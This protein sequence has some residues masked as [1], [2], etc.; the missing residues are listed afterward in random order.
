VL[1]GTV[2]LGD[3]IASLFGAI[4]VLVAL[5]HRDATGRGQ[6]IDVGIYEAV[7]R[8]LEEI[9]GV[10]GAQGKVREREGAGSF[11][12]VP[13]GHFRTQ[14]DRWIAIACTTDKMFERLSVA[15]GQPHLA[16]SSLYGDQRKRL[17]ARDT[18]NQLVIEW[19]ASLPRDEVMARCLEEEVPVGKVNSIADIFA[20]EQ[21][22]A[23]GNLA[24]VAVDGVGDVVVP[25][26][27]PTL[28]ATPG[29]VSGLGPALGNATD[30]VLR[31]LLGLA[32][33][34]VARLRTQRII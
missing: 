5:R 4:G 24:T 21:F 15:M 20:D 16:S 9:A 18:V 3:Y 26:V 17:A 8:V 6:L 11:V 30:A 19:V 1:P 7:F 27:V 34:E 33:A 25:G 29:R 13:H 31:D 10:Y 28:S 2:P 23:R 22:Q 14:D 32:A 12:A